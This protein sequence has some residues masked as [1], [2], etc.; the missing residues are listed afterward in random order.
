MKYFYFIVFSILIFTNAYSQKWEDIEDRYKR[1]YKRIITEGI[2]TS[3][4]YDEGRKI[5]VVIIKD[6][7][8]DEGYK[9]DFNY[10]GQPAVDLYSNDL[11]KTIFIKTQE[12]NLYELK[13]EKYS[14][15]LI[16]DGR[17]RDFLDIVFEKNGNINFIVKIK[18]EFS[19]SK[20]SFEIIKFKIK[21]QGF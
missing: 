17:N 18:R 8:E 3:F 6:L 11:I 12:G 16:I 14:S 20:D 1:E 7:Y 10:L 5:E 2:H 4:L 19:L 9:F 21:S 15:G 13:P